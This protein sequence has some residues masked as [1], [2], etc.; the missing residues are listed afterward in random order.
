MHLFFHL[1][2]ATIRTD[3]LA[4]G[5]RSSRIDVQQGPDKGAAL[6]GGGVAVGAVA[7]GVGVEPEDDAAPLFFRDGLAVRVS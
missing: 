3:S 7:E 2:A 5:K 6:L 1:P 4:T